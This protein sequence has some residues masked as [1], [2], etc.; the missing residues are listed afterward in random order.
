MEQHRVGE[1]A[2][3]MTVGQLKVQEVL[4]PDLAAAVFSRHLDKT[5]GAVQAD[6]RR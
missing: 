2:V 5:L 3:E 4:M 6:R 1:H